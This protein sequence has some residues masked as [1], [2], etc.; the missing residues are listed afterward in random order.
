M[1]VVCRAVPNRTDGAS[2]SR[3]VSPALAIVAA[4]LVLEGCA[5][6]HIDQAPTTAARGELRH[7]LGTSVTSLE[8][9]RSPWEAP[10][11]QVR[12]ELD[13]GARIGVAENVDVGLRVYFAGGELS[14]KVRLVDGPLELSVAPSVAYARLIPSNVEEAAFDLFTGTLSLLGG[15]RIGNHIRLTFGGSLLYLVRPDRGRAVQWTRSLSQPG[16]RGAVHAGLY[17]GHRRLWIGPEARFVSGAFESDDVFET[18]IGIFG[19]GIHI[20]AL[21]PSEVPASASERSASAS[22]PAP[23]TPSVDYETRGPR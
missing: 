16:P 18:T 1:R 21:L 23:Q 8:Y 11:S 14:A 3:R 7:H 6:L 12:P 9:R 13:Y 17:F 22:P 2:L 10:N 20:G 19:I 15:T 5:A 4:G